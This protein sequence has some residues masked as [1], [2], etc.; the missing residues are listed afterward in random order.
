MKY[1][2]QVFLVGFS[3]F[4]PFTDWR[5]PT[6]LA[7]AWIRLESCSKF[8][9]ILVITMY[10][11]DRNWISKTVYYNNYSMVCK[12]IFRSEFPD[13]PDKVGRKTRKRGTQAIA[14]RY[15]FQANA[16]SLSMEYIIYW[17]FGGFLARI[18]K[19]GLWVA[20]RIFTIKS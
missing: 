16:I 13:I 6:I 5:N 15:A 19:F 18:S 11:K 8:L 9:S 20:D 14:K 1:S 3:P 2:L 4:L 7:Y 10:F 17:I 12:I